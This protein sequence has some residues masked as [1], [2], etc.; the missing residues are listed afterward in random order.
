MGPGY[1]ESI[2]VHVG[3]GEWIIVDSCKEYGEGLP[4][5]LR[6]LQSIGVNAAKSVSI[7]AAT[8]WDQDHV[9]GMGELIQ[10]ATSAFF[11]CANAFG[12][13]EFQEYIEVN[14]I[15]SQDRGAKDITTAFEVLRRSGRSILMAYPG[16]IVVSRAAGSG[17]AVV[18][19][20]L[21]SLSPSDREHELFLQELASGMPNVRSPMRAAVARTPNLASVVLSFRWDEFA[22]LLGA[23]MEARAEID[24]GWN[25]VIAESIR[26]GNPKADLVKIPHHGSRTAHHDGMWASM[27][28]P[29]PLGVIAPFAKGRGASRPPTS[30]DIARIGPRVSKLFVTAPHV[31][32]KPVTRSA[33]VVR[34]LREGNIQVRNLRRPIGVVRFRRVSGQDWTH[35]TFGP[36]IRSK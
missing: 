1:G 27:L 14:T 9:R 21:Q 6:Y 7:V 22:V 20:Q 35:E 30:A 36:A 13:K 19:F 11:V 23:D 10:A 24:R 2:V 16:R 29:E 28:V 26:V 17:G 3:G 12:R 5:P 25:A 15:G 31:S 32:A 33:A 4:A 34:G 8:H 18:S